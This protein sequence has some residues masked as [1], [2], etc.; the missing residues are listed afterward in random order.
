MKKDLGIFS[1][2]GFDLPLEQRLLLIKKS[3]FKSTFI[4]L[5]DEK[6]LSEENKKGAT[7]KLIKKHNLYLEHAHASYENANF[8][9]SNISGEQEKIKTYYENCIKFCSKYK[10]PYLVIHPSKSSFPPLFNKSGLE[11]FRSLTF[12]AQKNNVKIAIEN[13]RVNKYTNLILKNI[14]SKNI[15][16]CYDT[17]HD[18]L[19]GDPTFGLVRKWSKRIFLTHISDNSRKKDDHFLPWKGTYDWEKFA[20]IFSNVKYKGILTLEVFPEK[21]YKVPVD[22]L[23]SAFKAGEK[24][25][26]LITKI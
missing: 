8:I 15:G 16:L 20:G 17:S 5:G 18:H 25:Q 10:I 9:W 21:K 2:F 4:L 7:P 23:N 13:T 1:H 14:K 3:G 22:F 19:Y 11:I 26:K 24:L 6:E 12:F